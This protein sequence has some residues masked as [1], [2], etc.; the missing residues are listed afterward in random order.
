MGLNMTEEKRYTGAICYT[1][2]KGFG[3]IKSDAMTDDV[4]FNKKGLPDHDLFKVET[5]VEFSLM[6]KKG[7]RDAAYKITPIK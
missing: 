4:Y 3:F 6:P 7:K 1:S 2:E 5:L